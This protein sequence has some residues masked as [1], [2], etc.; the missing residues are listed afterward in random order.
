MP[1]HNED[2]VVQYC[3]D[4][5][6]ELLRALICA[7]RRDMVTIPPDY[8]TDYVTVPPRCPC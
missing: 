6:A 4:D 3:D 1:C 2:I 8:V 5:R 7:G